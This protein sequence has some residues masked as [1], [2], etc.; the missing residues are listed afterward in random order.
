[1]FVFIIGIDPHKGSHTA[2][3]IDRDERLIDELA[4]HADRRQRDRL[5][6]FAGS[7]V[8][9]VWAVEG[10]TGTGYLLAQQ[11]V[12]AG[13]TV[14]D[15]P[16]ALS[17]RVRL[18]D[19]GRNDKNDLHDARSA[20]IVALRHPNLR[21]V[22][23]EDHRQ[24]LRL[25]ARRHHQLIAGRTRAICRLHAVLCELIEGGLTKNLSAKRAASELRKLRPTDSID[26]E[27]KQIAAEF[28]DEVRHHDHALVEL[29]RRIIAAVKA[30]DTTV[31]DV[32]GVG[33]IV[34]CYLIGYS[35]DVR[36]FPTA[37]HYA[38]YNATAPIETSS[39]PR[40]RHRLN[41]NGNR[42]LN[43]AIHI[44]ALGQI[45]HDTAGRAYYLRKQAEGKSRKEAM[46]CL[47]RRI[48][49]AIYA[50]LRADLD[51]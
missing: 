17:A 10:A 41:P 38:R 22:A 24:V 4:V 50:Q 47:K 2:A 33:P 46:R 31:T 43:H 6:K 49:D 29:H 48:S 8:P 36:R 18:L 7:F 3:V 42:Q 44:A 13:E 1:M 21:V 32:P 14:V 12:G 40:V 20:A 26:I 45:S 28:L 39:G 9:R 25:L 11:L 15:V 23:L 5:L 37:G 30:A 16:A 27:R 51:H 35:G 34:A 19:A